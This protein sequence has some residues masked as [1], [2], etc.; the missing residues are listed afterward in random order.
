MRK[1]L[2]VTA[3]GF[4]IA[5]Q[6]ATA[7]AADKALY[8]GTM[9]VRWNDQEPVPSLSHSRI[10]NP[11]ST[12]EMHVDC[13]IIHRNF[14]P[15]SGNNLDD[16]DI[17]IIDTSASRNA[18]CWLA[19]RYQINATLFGTTNSSASTGFGNYEQNLDFT[20]TGRHPQN[21]Y[22]IGCEIPRTEHGHQSGITYYS[23]QE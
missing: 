22:Y 18:R 7:F 19:S 15:F 17:G 1:L 16:A 14:N 21:W 12:H 8:P 13:P 5:L 20:S 4:T 23:A 10:F 3:L 6:T 11:S 2:V 9:C